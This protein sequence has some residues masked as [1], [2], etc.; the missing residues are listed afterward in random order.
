MSSGGTACPKRLQPTTLSGCELYIFTLLC[1]GRFYVVQDKHKIDHIAHIV[2]TK[3]CGG[4]PASEIE[5]KVKFG[6]NE[7]CFYGAPTVIFVTVKTDANCKAP[8]FK[9]MDLGFALQNLM[10][11]ATAE[12]LDTVPVGLCKSGA[13]RART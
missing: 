12:G 2:D 11:A 9:L 10:L 7:I 1:A 3:I 6:V 13:S 8:Y 4:K 5:R